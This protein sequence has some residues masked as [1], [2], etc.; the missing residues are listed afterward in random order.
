MTPK[1]ELFVQE[2]LVDLNGTQ[3]AIRAGYS[4]R[5]AKEQA[6][7]MLAKPEIAA[8]INAAMGDRAEKLEL[9]A[10][11]VLTEIS[12]MAFYDPAEIM[13]EIGKADTELSDGVSV[14]DDGKI[15][16][17]RGPG[18]V[19]RLPDNVRRAIVGWS[20]DR[21]GNFTVKLADKSKA[22]D[23]LARHLSLYNDKL[24]IGGFDNLADRLM[25][26]D[27][28]QADV[29]PSAAPVMSEPVPKP[30]P[31]AP[32]GPGN[33]DNQRITTE[34]PV[35]ERK[36]PPPTEDWNAPAQSPVPAYRPILPAWPDDDAVGDVAADYD[37]LA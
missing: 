22:L 19:R 10:E 9:T 32:A 31:V 6:A 35:S 8:A 28:R 29:K 26:A 4:E 1:Q 30:A 20:W 2:F 3:A 36:A 24:A 13:L 11:R 37:P 5:T 12:A 23:Q 17:L 16:G 18:D 25:R 14:S 34:Q 33:V 7:Q 15:Y 27:A 21:N